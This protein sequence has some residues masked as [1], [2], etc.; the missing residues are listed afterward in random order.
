MKLSDLREQNSLPAK[1]PAQIPNLQNH[2]KNIVWGCWLGSNNWNK[3][4]GEKIN[5]VKTAI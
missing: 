2:E 1:S 3:I 4:T 5:I